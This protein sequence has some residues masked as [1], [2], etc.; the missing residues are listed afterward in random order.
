MVG[1]AT[2]QSIGLIPPAQRGWIVKV[3]SNGCLGPGDPQCWP[4]AV[5][6]IQPTVSKTKVYPNPN[7][8]RFTI[9][10]MLEQGE[11]GKVQITDLQGRLIEEVVLSPMLSFQQMDLSK[12]ANG[13]Y[14]YRFVVNGFDPLQW[15]DRSN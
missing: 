2:D 7:A 11:E 3:D 5:P 1:E 12:Q 10:Y 4:T 8:G 14:F 9:Q 15:E 6:E 13:I